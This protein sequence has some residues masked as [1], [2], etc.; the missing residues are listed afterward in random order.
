MPPSAPA[1]AGRPESG[2]STTLGKHSFTDDVASGPL[3]RPIGVPYRRDPVP[4]MGMAYTG[5]CARQPAAGS[6][7]GTPL[8]SFAPVRTRHGVFARAAAWGP[9]G[10]GCSVLW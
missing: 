7:C 4:Y 6:A 8:S 1:E 10:W 2:A 9:V 3:D 5:A